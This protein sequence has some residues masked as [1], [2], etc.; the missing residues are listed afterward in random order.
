[1]ICSLHVGGGG[2][3]YQQTS[4]DDTHKKDT[5]N[6]NQQKIAE[7]IPQDKTNSS[8]FLKN[9]TADMRINNSSTA[10]KLGC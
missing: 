3:S 8:Y 5:Q 9:A 7:V 1:M 6:S 2:H 4:Q 10:E